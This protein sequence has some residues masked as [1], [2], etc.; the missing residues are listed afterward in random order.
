MS[1]LQAIILKAVQDAITGSP[2]DRRLALRFF[3]DHMPKEALEPPHPGFT[4]RLVKG[5][6]DL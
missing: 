4:I 2:A 3:A 1:C 6:E 5:D